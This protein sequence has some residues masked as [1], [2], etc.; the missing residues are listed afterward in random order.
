MPSDPPSPTQGTASATARARAARTLTDRHTRLVAAAREVLDHLD[1]TVVAVSA[2]VHDDERRR[3]RAELAQVDATR[4]GEMTDRNLRLSAVQAAG[5]LTAADLLDVGPR[6]LAA[7]P[8]VGETTARGVVAAVG[9]LA[10]AAA[11][12]HPL[13]VG[14]DR[15]GLP[16]PAGADRLLALLHRVMRLRP[17]V[18]PHRTTLDDY[19]TATTAALATARPARHTARLWVARPSTRRAAHAGLT[20]LASWDSSPAGAGLPELLARLGAAVAEPDPGPFDLAADFERRSAEYYTA[21]VGIAPQAQAVLSARGLLPQ[22]LV[23]RVNAQPL[24]LAAMRVSLRGYQEFGARFALHQGRAL[25]GDEMGLGKTVQA[26]AVM[27]HLRATG[28]RRFLVVCPASLL[29]NWAREVE[30]RT[31]MPAHRMH[32]ERRAEAIAAWADGGGVGLTTF[33]G[34]AHVP[35][36]VGDVGLLVVDE[37]HY[38]KNPRTGRARSVGAW[39]QRVWRVVFLTGTPMDNRLEDFLELVRVLQPDLAATFPGHLG[40]LGPDAFRQVV[41]PVYL[42]RNQADVL[43]ELPGVIA[44]DQWVD[45]T[46]ADDRAYREAVAAGNLMAMRRA[47]WAAGPGPQAC[48]KLSRLVEIVDEA[49]DEGR[50]TVVFSYFRDVLDTV[51]ATLRARGVTVHGP[52]SGDVPVAER[53]GL[54]DAF[55]DDVGAVLVAQI[56]VGGT[57]L[58]LHAASVVVL[59][60]PQLTPSA[61]EQAVARLHRMGQVRTV[62]AHRLLAED[63]VD[64][65]IVELLA[66]KQR[67]FDEYVRTSS[68]AAAAVAAVDVTE[69]TL[70]REVVAWEQARLGYGPWWDGLDAS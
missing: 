58:N 19:V 4:L 24:D 34:L 59:C 15:A 29:A 30:Q 41:A 26:L 45:L 5:Y 68:V 14:V 51:A 23:D 48:A 66:G 42:R 43:V 60:E 6:E 57:G 39:A 22:G 65:R 12:L 46:E 44:R 11:A 13:R 53:L 33:E 63:G 21:L 70:A 52:L 38:V 50:R 25:I 10:E 61:E 54:V 7:L 56:T 37:A 40:L 1:A 67:V 2:W 31:T 64:E 8:G 27:S 69:G 20:A 35:A 3:V 28:H 32:G 9:Q 18:E 16:T 36:D 17:L 62:H 55:A 47:A 49:R